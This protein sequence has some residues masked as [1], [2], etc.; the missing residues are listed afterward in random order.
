MEVWPESKERL[1]D[2]TFV[3]TRDM[4]LRGIYFLSDVKH[5]RGAR[6]NFSVIFLREF[7]REDTDLISGVARIVRCEL[8]STREPPRFGVA[9]AIEKTVHTHGE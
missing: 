3:R 7:T 4:S 1:P 2:P 8:L 6:L 5:E 9:L